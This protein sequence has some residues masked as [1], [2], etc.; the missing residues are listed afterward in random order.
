[1][2]RLLASHAGHGGAIGSNEGIDLERM[3]KTGQGA[4]RTSFSATDPKKEG[5]PPARSW[6]PTTTRSASMS[7][8]N[9]AITVVALPSCT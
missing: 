6:F 4:T 9:S 2:S 5:F 3:I 8:A 7:S 1:M